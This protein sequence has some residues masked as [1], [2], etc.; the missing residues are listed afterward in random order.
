MFAAIRRAGE[1]EYALGSEGARAYNE[2]RNLGGKTKMQIIS[3]RL[4]IMPRK[5]GTAGQSSH[6]PYNECK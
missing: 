1:S 5:R 4:D 3:L 2:I 6:P